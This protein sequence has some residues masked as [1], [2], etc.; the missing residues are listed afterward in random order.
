MAKTT[1]WTGNA[2]PVQQVVTWTL[3]GTWTADDIIT[4]EINDQQVSVPAG[5]T[6]IATIVVTLSAALVASTLDEFTVITW[7]DDGVDTIT[8]TAVVGGVPFV[9]ESSTSDAAALIEGTDAADPGT[10]VTACDGPNYF[11]TVGNWSNGLPVSTDTIIFSESDINC[12]QDLDQ[13]AITSGNLIV[14]ASYTGEIGLSRYRTRTVPISVPTGGE[15]EYR[16]RYL[17]IGVGSIRIGDGDGP[18][19]NLILVDTGATTTSAVVNKTV[20]RTDGKQSFR[21]KGSDITIA[22]NRGSV[23]IAS[24]PGDTATITGEV[25]VS[26]VTKLNDSNVMIGSGATLSSAVLNVTAGKLLVQSSFATANVSGTGELT[27]IGSAT[28]TTVNSIDGGRVFWNSSGTCTTAKAATKGGFDFI[29]HNISKTFTNIS[30]YAGAVWID[31][32]GTVTDTNGFDFVECHQ[33]DCHIWKPKP[34][35][36]WTSSVI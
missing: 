2:Q 10:E 6:V 7:T 3:S 1:V 19:S 17:Q 33:G 25:N 35:R 23:G 26:K 30:V 31:P 8:G 22:V 11:G 14:N 5:D 34:N 21:L 27:V 36:T 16:A 18:G 20:A 29:R 32:M 15:F 9:C 13:T 28:G 12:T 24:E 4:F